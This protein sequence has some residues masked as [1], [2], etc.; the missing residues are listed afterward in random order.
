MICHADSEEG[1]V[2]NLLLLC[3]KDF[4]KCYAD[5]HEDMNGVVFETWFRNAL[6]SNLPKPWFRN[7]LL[8][9]LP[10]GRKVAIVFD[11]IKYHSRFVERSPAMNTRK[12]Q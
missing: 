7:A 9:N 1:F 10:K 11:N 4:A 3:G 2:P 5:Y 6:L 8:P 12:D